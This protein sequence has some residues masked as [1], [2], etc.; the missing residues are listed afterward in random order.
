VCL[1]LQLKQLGG[2]KFLQCVFYELYLFFD[3]TQGMAVTVENPG[4]VF[5]AGA[6][7]CRG[8]PG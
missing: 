2:K 3:P 1:E 5:D 8:K 4:I 7:P 6:N